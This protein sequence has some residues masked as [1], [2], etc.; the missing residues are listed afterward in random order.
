MPNASPHRRVLKSDLFGE[1]ALLDGDT[2]L[3][4]RDTDAAPWWTRGVARALARREARSLNAVTGLAGVPQLVEFDGRRLIRTYLSGQPMHVAR[5]SDPDY[6]TAA[7]R[8]LF[9]LHTRDVIHNDTAKEPNWLVLDDG[10]PGLIDF[11]LAAWRPQRGRLFRLLAREDVRH[12]LKHKRTYA[13]DRLTHRQKRILATP[14][15]TSRIWR[16][17]VKPLYHFVTRRV[18]GWADREGA[19]DRG[20]QA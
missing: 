6:F 12:L 19:G 1:V 8:L 15:A 20:N 3:I 16:A 17:T 18:L 2:P 11:Q 10:R 7:Q 5:P 14:G 4:E 13:A 9:T